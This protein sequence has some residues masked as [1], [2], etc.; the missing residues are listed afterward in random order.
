MD[1]TTEVIPSSENIITSP[2]GGFMFAVI[3]YGL[4]LND[5]SI[6]YFDIELTQGYYTPPFKIINET[7]I[8]LV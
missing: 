7:K 4:N 3:M 2:E 6:K 1:I 8:P 5:P